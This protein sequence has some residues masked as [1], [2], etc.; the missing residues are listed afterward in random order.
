MIELPEGAKREPPASYDPIHDLT[1]LTELAG[2]LLK[3]RAA[4]AVFFPGGEALRSPAH[5]K[6][7]LEQKVSPLDRLK[8]ELEDALEQEDYEQA[9]ELRDRIR[10][11]KKEFE[12]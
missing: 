4:S 6:Q 3:M 1:T 12:L 11:L 9:A 2:A 5:V 8:R 7:V 10:A